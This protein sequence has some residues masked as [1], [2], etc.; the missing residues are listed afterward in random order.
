M[1]AGRQSG[2]FEV[3][4]GCTHSNS[5]ALNAG[6]GH[7][8]VSKGEQVGRVVSVQAAPEVFEDQVLDGLISW[9][10]VIHTRDQVLFAQ[11]CGVLSVLRHASILVRCLLLL[12]APPVAR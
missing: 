2:L 3:H 11:F 9:E 8:D 7:L 1:L 10:L 5:R 4:I 12:I 6:L